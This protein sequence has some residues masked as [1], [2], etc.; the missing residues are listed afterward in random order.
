MKLSG[1]ISLW[2]T[3]LL[4]KNSI[5]RAISWAIL[6][7]CPTLSSWSENKR[8]LQYEEQ[9]KTCLSLVQPSYWIFTL[10]SHSCSILSPNIC[11][12]QHG[13]RPQSWEHKHSWALS[14][15]WPPYVQK[16]DIERVGIWREEAYFSNSC[17]AWTSFCLLITFTA[18]ALPLYFPL[19]TV[20]KPPWPDWFWKPKPSAFELRK[21][22]G[23]EETNWWH[24]CLYVIRV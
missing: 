2:I 7:M 16:L 14:L 20:E 15:I 6:K 19:Y 17:R 10:L 3:P 21:R 24:Q 22:E 4:C 1:L 18:T 9:I 12:L 8:R 23:R 11:C 5:A 13:T